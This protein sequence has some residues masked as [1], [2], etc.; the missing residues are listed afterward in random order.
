[1]QLLFA[2]P[3]RNTH[4]NT[5]HRQF[6]DQKAAINLHAFS[7]L[8]VVKV[9]E[10]KQNIFT[11]FRFRPTHQKHLSNGTCDPVQNGTQKRRN[12]FAYLFMSQTLTKSANV[13][14]VM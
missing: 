14:I 13:H 9:K 6:P 10:N 1:M 8:Y 2:C 3:Q 7:F 12:Y 4:W 11:F 5:Q